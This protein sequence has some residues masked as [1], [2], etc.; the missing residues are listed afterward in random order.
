MERRNQ[1]RQERAQKR[2]AEL[3][4]ARQRRSESVAQRVA[5]LQQ[6]VGE[7]ASAP[8]QAELAEPESMEE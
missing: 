6:S 7:R 4:A 8:E 3:A 1:Q 5:E 2:Q